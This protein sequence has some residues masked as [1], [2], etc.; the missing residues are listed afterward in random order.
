MMDVTVNSFTLFASSFAITVLLGF[1]SQIV[2]L[3]QKKMSFLL[4][5][6]IGTSQI[7]SFKLVPNAGSIELVSFVL[8]GA[9]GIVSSITLHNIY[10]KY[11]GINDTRG[12]SDEHKQNIGK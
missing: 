7:F 3:G 11:R 1:Q 4:S 5:L 2:R 9:F 10:I 6:C 12:I 8:G